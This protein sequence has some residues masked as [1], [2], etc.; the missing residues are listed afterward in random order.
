MSLSKQEFTNAGRAML[1]RAQNGETLTIS[2]L[3]VGSGT[4]TLPDDLWPLT[5]L[6]A[7]QLDVDISARRD[8]GNGT[9]LVE[10][11]FLSSEAA[12]AFLLREVG[13]MAHIAAETDQLYSVANVLADSPDTVDPASP[14]VQA[15]KVKLVIDRIPAAN[16]VIQIGPSENVI[17]ENVGADTVGPG[18]YKEV[19]ANVLRFKRIAAG[20]GISVTED[21]GQNT[22]T[23][24][25]K[26]LSIDTDLYVD[27][28]FNN[29]APNFSTINN[30]FAYLAPFYIPSN[31]VARINC[32]ANQ[33]SESLNIR[34]P[35][36]D[37]IQLIGATPISTNVT[38][39]N[40]VD[41][42]TFNVQVASAT[43]LAVGDLVVLRWTSAFHWGGHYI[44]AINGL[45][46][47]LHKLYK[48]GIDW[49][50][51][52]P[53][54]TL[55]KYPT[56]L[57]NPT[58]AIG[59]ALVPLGKVKNLT[60][61]GN[62]HAVGSYGIAG[63]V[64]SLEEVYIYNFYS[65]I[66][67]STSTG[68][69]CVATGLTVS[70]CEFGIVVEGGCS[71]STS[72]TVCA[73]GNTQ[74]GMLVRNG[75][76]AIIGGTPPSLDNKQAMFIGNGNGVGVFAATVELEYCYITL[77]PTGLEVRDNGSL[78]AGNQPNY[79]IYASNNT[80]DGYAVDRGFIK[81]QRNTGGG[82]AIADPPSGVVGNN[83]AYIIVT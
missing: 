63:N 12:A 35:Q 42:Q 23:V 6:V 7:H 28:T 69:V 55:A 39:I 71:L 33:F 80:K 76:S 16:L 41:A 81:I 75:G 45:V 68:G 52:Y 59:S 13:I 57:Y 51:T 20:T 32:S 27:P 26:V 44:T 21:A 34:H 18:V 61:K 67:L 17:G 29:V 50:A 2:K 36:A 65:G 62:G 77:Q 11:S 74:R 72:G 1:G 43:G 64:L 9:M 58:V 25:Q 38:A 53:G 5:S 4:V 47:T 83:Q 40:N 56:V 15:F 46:I 31:L 37:R 30:A 70:N 8:Y 24:G 78:I 14:S 10:G 22:I 60:I 54:G 66:T 3:V 19:A 82:F 79:P 48:G 49:T 73:N